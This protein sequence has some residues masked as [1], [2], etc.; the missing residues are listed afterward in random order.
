M[1]RIGELQMLV[2]HLVIL[3]DQLL[4]AAIPYILYPN[5]EYIMLNCFGR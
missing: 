4:Q 3:F 5:I 2:T 1:G